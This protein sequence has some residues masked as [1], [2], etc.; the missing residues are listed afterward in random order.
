MKRLFSR[1]RQ[2]RRESKR[3]WTKGRMKRDYGI[4][5]KRGL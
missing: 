3:D 5:K 1:D 2:R 4:E